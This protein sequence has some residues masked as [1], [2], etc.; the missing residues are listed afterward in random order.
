[1]RPEVDVNQPWGLSGPQFLGLYLGVFALSALLAVAVRPALRRGPVKDAGWGDVYTLAVL[2]GGS[3]RVVD[4][5]V[6]ALVEG[7]QLR[8]GR[9]HKLTVCG[10]ATPD[11]PV[12]Q[13]VLDRLGRAGSTDLAGARRMVGRTE[14][15][16]QV[17]HQAIHRGLLLDP[18][19]RRLARLLVLLP[20]AVFGVGIARLVNGIREG[21]PIGFL[22]FA[23]IVTGML[24]LMVALTVP[25][26]TRAGQEL[27]ER[28]RRRHQEGAEPQEFGSYGA[29]DASAYGGYGSPDEVAPAA[30]LSVA[31]L[32]AVGVADPTLRQAL[33]GGPGSSGGGGGG[34][35]G[36]SGGDGGGGSG[37]GGGGCGGGGCGG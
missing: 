21:R 25:R 29:T 5:A 19:Q 24:L 1:V 27:L 2:S 18:A 16:Q 6:Q 13:A 36:D 15:V 12:Q 28:A 23:L 30:V 34:G 26:A 31:V 3:I 14:P 37:C 17:T 7:G 20:T 11:E 10:E 32:G 4:T 9:D 35:G 22:I 8:A 33:Y